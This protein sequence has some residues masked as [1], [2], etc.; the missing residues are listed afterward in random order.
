M[1]SCWEK[2]SP[3]AGWAIYLITGNNQASLQL[4]KREHVIFLRLGA[5]RCRNSRPA[6]ARTYVRVPNC[7]FMKSE[8]VLIGSSSHNLHSGAQ[9]FKQLSS[10][11]NPRQIMVLV[12]Y[13]YT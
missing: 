9:M 3:E 4:F 10:T 8:R 7:I 12:T 2:C 13:A 1:S 6:P 11:S 5:A